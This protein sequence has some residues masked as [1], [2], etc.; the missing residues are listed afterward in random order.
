MEEEEA[1]EEDN[2]PTYYFTNEDPE[3]IPDAPDLMPLNSDGEEDYER[4]EL[5][6]EEYDI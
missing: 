4:Y 1:H 2:A 3:S 5:S 6:E